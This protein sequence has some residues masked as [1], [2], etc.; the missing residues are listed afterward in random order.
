MENLY[1]D[2]VDSMRRHPDLLRVWVSNPIEYVSAGEV[3][4]YLFQKNGKN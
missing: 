2:I 1:R 4:A 3:W